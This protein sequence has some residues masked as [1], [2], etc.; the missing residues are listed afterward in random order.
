[1]F[2]KYFCD[3]GLSIQVDPQSDFTL[4]IGIVLFFI[5]VNKLDNCFVVHL[6]EP[7]MFHW[8]FMQIGGPI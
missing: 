2:K 6:L 4:K 7:A 5:L 3:A 1:M 8:R